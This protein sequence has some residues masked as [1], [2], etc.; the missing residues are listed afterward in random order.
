MLEIVRRRTRHAWLL[1]VWLIFS[2]LLLPAGRL[3]RADE[4]DGFTYT[5]TQSSVAVSA[6]A[7]SGTTGMQEGD[8]RQVLTYSEINTWEIWTNSDTGA[9]EVRNPLTVPLA[10]TGMTFGASGDGAV[11]PSS[12]TADGSG[13]AVTTFTAGTTISTVTATVTAYGATG[14]VTFDTPIIPETWT[15][16]SDQS[17]ITASLSA[18]G[19]TD[20]V[21]IGATRD[22]QAYV[23]Y[24]SWSVEVS[25][26]GNHRTVGYQTSPAI[27]AT[28]S[29]SM[30]SGDG[31]VS[32]SSSTADN[33]GNATTTFTMQSAASV[34]R[35]DVSYATSSGTY[36]TL[37]FTPAAVE[38]TWM[39]DHTDSSVTNLTL[40]ANGSTDGLSQGDVRTLTAA[41]TSTS[42]EV[43]ISNLGNTEYRNSTTGPG[44]GVSV[45]FSLD[46][47]DGSLSG[48]SATTDSSGNASVN[49]TMGSAQSG[50]GVT[51]SAGSC[52]ASITFGADGEMWH[53]DHSEK[54]QW[55]SDFSADGSTDLRPG[56]TRTLTAQVT[57]ETWD[58]EVSNYGNYRSVNDSTGTASGVTVEFFVTSGDGS[59]STGSAT[60]DG[61]GHAS[62]V[63]TMAT[64]ASV[65][66]AYADN[67]SGG[68]ASTS[69]TL[70]LGNP[71]WT[72]DHTETTISTSLTA[73]GSTDSLPPGTI[74]VVTANVSFHSW[75][76][77][78]DDAS[79][80]ENRNYASGAANGASM[81][82]S[83]TNDGTLSNAQSSTNAD[84]NATATFTMGSQASTVQ[85]DAS[86][87][88]A[89]SSGTI[90]FTPD[91]W[92]YD[93]SEKALSVSLVDN[94]DAST[95]AATVTYTTWDVYTNGS[96]Y[97][98]RYYS[99]GPAGGASVAFSSDGDVTVATSSATTDTAGT[100]STGYACPP[101]GQGTITAD[102]S[103][104]GAYASDTLNIT[105]PG[106]SGSP[107]TLTRQGEE[108][109]LS[110]DTE[111]VSLYASGGRAP[112]PTDG[113][114]YTEGAA[115]Y[116]FMYSKL[117]G[118]P[119]SGVAGSS[120]ILLLNRDVGGYT[121]VTVELEQE[122]IP[123]G[124]SEAPADTVKTKSPRSTVQKVKIQ[125]PT[126]AVRNENGVQGTRPGG[127]VGLE[128]T[129]D[130]KDQD[131]TILKSGGQPIRETLSVQVRMTSPEAPGLSAGDQLPR[132]VNG[133]IW[134]V[135]AQGQFKDLIGCEPV[136]NCKLFDDLVRAN[137]GYIPNGGTVSIE[138]KAMNH[139]YS[140]DAPAG[141]PKI[142]L[143]GTYNRTVIIEMKKIDVGNWQLQSV[144]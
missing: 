133:L 53:F 70:T 69:I 88:G 87:A 91:P 134:I 73:D 8:T 85:A 55:F 41:V 19:S 97:E 118:N 135:S 62:T 140:I 128:F 125:K 5:S 21:P 136:S 27:G 110:S 76:V 38:E 26:L 83:V 4:G 123:T 121:D 141:Y 144:R 143:T 37:G 142:P 107:P 120:S 35:A 59:I 46:Y 65:V 116:I 25:N 54:T 51:A 114:T 44:A 90:T 115:S 31:A 102:A 3:I 77:Y 20:N 96:T 15:W 130:V 13:N 12:T 52:S 81:Y 23:E 1:H 126:K 79:N 139:S 10:G 103:F 22:V 48:S 49:F 124:A 95:V 113:G 78:V 112:Y 45:S 94:A 14:T 71:I 129:H 109:V 60:T 117:N 138:V 67:G 40:G 30:D 131:D 86:Y 58:V 68:T 6:W 64:Q 57:A 28:V 72:Y 84:G 33:S 29:W 43:W 80:T 66:E 47:G 7:P 75:D 24:S 9:T 89:Y 98:D 18:S 93:H 36:A 50:S 74:R 42:Y 132:S 11:S 32:P 82:F 127:V 17:L 99:S 92:T 63:F 2:L 137:N 61:S 101:G 106:D 119:A 16:E 105:S 111:K 39:Y 122:W 56:N 100:A 108:Y 104:S 34:V